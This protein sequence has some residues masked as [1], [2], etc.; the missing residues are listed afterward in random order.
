MDAV[1]SIL[2]NHHAEPLPAAF[3][4]IGGLVALKFALG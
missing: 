1:A 2:A 4:A 3:V